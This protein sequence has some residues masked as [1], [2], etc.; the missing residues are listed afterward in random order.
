MLLMEIL[1]QILQYII[2][3][4]ENKCDLRSVNLIEK[5]IKENWFRKIVY[6]IFYFILSFFKNNLKLSFY[7][8][9]VWY[10]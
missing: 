4:W 6:F 9:N 5:M 3:A 2:I 1:N 7:P 10:S 8:D